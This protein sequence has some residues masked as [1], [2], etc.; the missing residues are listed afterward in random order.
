[1]V[2]QKSEKVELQAISRKDKKAKH[3]RNE[4]F[5]PAILYGKKI[6]NQD[7]QI[8]AL[9][10]AAIIREHGTT[11][12]IDLK[13]DKDKDVKVLIREPQIHPV[14]HNILHIDLFQVD[15]SQKITSAIPVVFQGISIAV[16][17]LGGSLMETKSEVEVE[18]LPQDLPSE[19]V[20]NIDALKTF[21]DVLHVK[22]LIVPA[23][24]E[25]LDE[26]DEVLASVAEPR[27]EEELAALDE[28]ISEDV[29]S[30]DVV[31]G[32]EEV[33]EGEE[34]EGEGEGEADKTESGEADTAKE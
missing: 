13:I 29:D 17:D 32:K 15:L 7:L 31:E 6:T 19:L 33:T 21:E 25:I 8:D 5:T 14:T 3:L 22:D 12:L 10:L 24:V 28:E 27:S 11:S 9:K 23:G 34:E 18:C 4:G 2:S 16:D 1:M 26:P 30:V 20:A